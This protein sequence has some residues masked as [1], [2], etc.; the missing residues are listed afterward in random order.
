MVF[1]R[2]NSVG[3]IVAVSAEAAQG[4]DEQL[5]AGDK[6]LAGFL[7][8]VQS[9]SNETSVNL[10]A[11]DQ[12]FIRVLEDLIELLHEK[13]VISIA[14][15]PEDARDKVLLRQQL[16]LRLSGGADARR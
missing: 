10:Q 14:E 11:T 4:F 6:T 5:A 16:R 1:V 9:G 7:G 15:L 8:R 12:G 3:H 13:G 2:R